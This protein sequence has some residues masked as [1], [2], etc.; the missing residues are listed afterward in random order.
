[1]LAT[2]V[3]WNPLLPHVKLYWHMGHVT[4]AHPSLLTSWHLQRGH[5][6]MSMPPEASWYCWQDPPVDSCQPLVWHWK[7]IFLL[8]HALVMWGWSCTNELNKAANFSI[9]PLLLK[10][11]WASCTNSP[12]ESP[13]GCLLSP[14][15]LMKIFVSSMALDKSCSST[16]RWREDAHFLGGGGP[17]ESSLQPNANIFLSYRTTSGGFTGVLTGFFKTIPPIILAC[18]ANWRVLWHPGQRMESRAS[19]IFL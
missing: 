17:G 8:Q 10:F 4:S 7:Q 2:W 12:S 1:M 3:V 15:S 9:S 18:P 16:I 5:G 6:N 13:R 11:S 19:N 14:L